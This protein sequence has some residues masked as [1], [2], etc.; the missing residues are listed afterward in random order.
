[1]YVNRGPG[2]CIDMVLGAVY[3]AMPHVGRD[4]GDISLYLFLNSR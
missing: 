1:V 3:L 2:E 4:V